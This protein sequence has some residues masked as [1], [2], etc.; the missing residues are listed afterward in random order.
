MKAAGLLL[1]FILAKLA[2][3]TGHMPSWSLWTAIAYFWQD[4]LV[5]LLILIAGTV[6]G[7]CIGHWSFMSR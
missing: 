6:L 4:V 7:C 5:G 2:V 3:L 1:V